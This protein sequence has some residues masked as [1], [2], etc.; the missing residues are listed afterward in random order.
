M[1]TGPL[2]HLDHDDF[3]V[4]CQM[5]AGGSTRNT[6]ADDENISFNCHAACLSTGLMTVHV[7]ARLPHVGCRAGRQE[8]KACRTFNGCSRAASSQIAIAPMAARA[9][10]MPFPPMAIAMA[11]P[12]SRSR[13]DIMAIRVSMACA[14]A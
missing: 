13:R 2:L 5:G 6:G 7:R 1:V 14:A 4:L 10:S 12:C 11:L 9:N 3:A 8:R